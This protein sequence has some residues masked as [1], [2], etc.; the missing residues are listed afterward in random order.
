VVG[1]EDIVRKD[2]REMGTSWESVKTEA[3]SRL[4]WRRR[5]HSCVGLRWM[6]AIVNG[7]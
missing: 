6:G 3:L 4:G 5:V 7:Y 1:W 2:L